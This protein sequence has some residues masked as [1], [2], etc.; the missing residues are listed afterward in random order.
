MKYELKIEFKNKEKLIDVIQKSYFE[1]GNMGKLVGK[2]DHISIESEDPLYIIFRGLNNMTVKLFNDE[3][4]D[5]SMRC[6]I[7]DDTSNMINLFPINNY[8]IIEDKSKKYSFY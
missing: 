7:V 6:I 5:G 8:C 1:N 4:V 2:K 3:I